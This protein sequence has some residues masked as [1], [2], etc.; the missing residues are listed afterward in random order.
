M[1]QKFLLYSL[2][3]SIISQLELNQVEVQSMV[4]EIKED[5]FLN[6]AKSSNEGVKLNDEYILLKNSSSVMLQNLKKLL[7]S[8]KGQ[9]ADKVLDPFKIVKVD[10]VGIKKDI[11][12]KSNFLHILN[13]LIYYCQVPLKVV[14]VVDSVE[15]QSMKSTSGYYGLH[16]TRDWT[17]DQKKPFVLWT[18]KFY[19]H[20]RIKDQPILQEMLKV[21]VI[22]TRL[23]EEVQALLNSAD[24]YHDDFKAMAISSLNTYPRVLVG[25]MH[26]RKY[27]DSHLFIS[28]VIQIKPYGLEIDPWS[29]TEDGTRILSFWATCIDVFPKMK[30]LGETRTLQIVIDELVKEDFKLTSLIMDNFLWNQTGQESTMNE[31]YFSHTTKSKSRRHLALQALSDFHN[32]I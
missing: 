20:S 29:D 2:V 28:L 3:S 9:W 31:L 12:K 22:Q 4:L 15:F 14:Q 24:P 18:S 6:I 17:E 10:H 32:S 23:I 25:Y 5:Y 19:L 8:A 21:Q 13:E 30:K 7:V 26:L 16:L 27:S 11:Q 1:K